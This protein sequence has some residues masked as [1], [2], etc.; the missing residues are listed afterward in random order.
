M[1]PAPLTPQTLEAARVWFRAEAR[2]Y[3]WTLTDDPYAIWI[4]EVMLQQTVVTAAVLPYTAWME[5]W[6]SLVAL[7]AASEDQVL[8]AWEGLGYASRAQNLHR[9]AQELVARGQSTLPDTEA[10]LRAL[11]GIGE[12]TAAAVLSFAFHQPALTL[13]ANLKRVFQR[14]DGEPEWTREVDTRWRGQWAGLVDGP[15]SR[16][17]NQA[18]MQLG[19]RI[20][21]TKSPQC[22]VCPLAPGCRARAD[23]TWASVPAPRERTVVEKAT[24][25]VFWH[26]LDRSEWWLARPG[27][28]RFSNLWMAPPVDATALSPAVGALWLTSRVHTYTKYRDR[29][30]PC[31]APWIE[32]N[33]PPIPEGWVGRWATEVEARSLGMVSV[34]R[35]VFE[36]ACDKGQASD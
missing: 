13:D 35:R 27:A 30:T 24:T 15:S 11:P 19:Q 18:I 9:T 31:S 32:P 21:R 12:Y 29:L 14:L 2:A 5:R 7:A 4:S 1:D 23:E 16:E 33:D 20:C 25:V 10:E 17:S 26:R 22:P 34:Y 3:P 28:G 8:R 6:P 36:E